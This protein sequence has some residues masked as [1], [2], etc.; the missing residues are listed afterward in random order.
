MSP[1]WYTLILIILALLTVIIIIGTVSVKKINYINDKYSKYKSTCEIT[2]EELSTILISNSNINIDIAKINSKNTDIYSSK[3]KVLKLSEET[4][5]S[6][7]ITSLGNISHEI[8]CAIQDSKNNF[9]YKLKT[10]LLPIINSMLISFIPL[11][12]IGLAFAFSFN[13]NTIGLIITI[14]SCVCLALS[15][16]FYLITIISVNKS[17]EVICFE[18]DKLKFF[19]D[20]ELV[21]IKTVI[22]SNSNTHLFNMIKYLFFLIYSFTNI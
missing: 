4:A 3:Y 14:I 7:S 1:V 19:T 5:K 12:L 18:L 17:S 9:I 8:G 20:N 21:A 2:T 11:F 16:I 6:V 13:L 15:I 10:R 22:Y